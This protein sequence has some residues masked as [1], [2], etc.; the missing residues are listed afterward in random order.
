M[1]PA[2]AA[3]RGTITDSSGEHVYGGMLISLD[4]N[5]PAPEYSSTNAKP[6]VSEVRLILTQPVTTNLE[7]LHTFIDR[8]ADVCSV[9]ATLNREDRG[10]QVGA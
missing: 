5:Q 9:L 3:P 1:I 8:R 10:R 6:D 7:D 4:P 2:D